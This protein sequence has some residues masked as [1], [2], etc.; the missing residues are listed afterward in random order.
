MKYYRCERL[1]NWSDITWFFEALIFS[2]LKLTR[3]C[4][5]CFENVHKL[6]TFFS[7]KKAAT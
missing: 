4:V 2:K 6:F 5:F 1:K 7:K 3:L